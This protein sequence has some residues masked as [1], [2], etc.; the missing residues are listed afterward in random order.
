MVRRSAPVLAFAAGTAYF[1]LVGSLPEAA[2]GVA[3]VAGALAVALC[4]LGPL[5]GRDDWVALVVLG[6]G[7]ALLSAALTGQDVG[8]A[9]NPVE[10]VF[11]ASVGLLFALAFAVPAAVVALP[12]LVAGIDVAAVFA[13]GDGGLGGFDPVDVLTFDLPLWGG[14]GSVSSLSLLDAT[15]LALFAAWSLHYGLRP[16]VAIPAMV[17]GLVVAALLAVAVDRTIPALPLIALGLLL[18]AIDKLPSL[19]RSA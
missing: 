6:G 4:A 19:L 10:A 18:P 11:A 12:L 15:F 5:A 8:A 7:A 2:R 9:A 3:A 1:L 17:L 14:G 16:R 13:A